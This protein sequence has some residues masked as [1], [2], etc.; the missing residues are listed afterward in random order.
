MENVAELKTGLHQVIAETDD[1]DTLTKIKR[2]ISGLIESEQKTIAY[3]HNNKPLTPVDYKEEIDSAIKEA[4]E[5][6]VISVDDL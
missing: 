1:L 6:K 4:K 2:Y 3:T 5:G